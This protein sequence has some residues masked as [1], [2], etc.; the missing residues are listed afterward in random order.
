MTAYLAPM[1]EANWCSKRRTFSSD[2]SGNNT[3]FAEI[4]ASRH[5][6]LGL[7]R[8]IFSK[9]PFDYSFTFI[10]PLIDFN[11]HFTV[12]QKRDLASLQF[13]EY[14]PMYNLQSKSVNRLTFIWSFPTA[15][16]PILEAPHPILSKK[17]RPVAENEFGADLV[18]LLND[19]AETMYDAP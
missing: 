14:T 1:Y 10:A 8:G 19:M 2:W 11:K 16:L 17:A 5:E 13:L 3:S 6:K 15:L 4:A 7:K 9:I 12:T 18:Q